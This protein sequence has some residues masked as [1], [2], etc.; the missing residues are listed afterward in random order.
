MTKIHQTVVALL[1]FTFSSKKA[2]KSPMKCKTVFITG[3][4]MLFA[5][6][7]LCDLLRCEGLTH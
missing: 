4:F 2:L 5:G 1:Y 3:W 6:R 7:R